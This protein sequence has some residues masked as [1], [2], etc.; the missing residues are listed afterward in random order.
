M[1]GK[2]KCYATM[3]LVAICIGYFAPNYAQYQLSPLAPGL[4]EELGINASQFSSLFTSPMIPA[5]FLSLVAGILV[6][7]FNPKLVVGAALIAS[8]VGAFLN[9]VGNSYGALFLGFAL[10]GL[11]ASFL[12]SCGAKL[13]GAWYEPDQ[14]SAKLGVVYAASTL[15]MTVAIATTAYFPNRT[16]AF[17]MTFILF[18][19]ALF[20]WFVFYRSPAKS[21]TEAKAL[22]ESAAPVRAQESLGVTL[23]WVMANRY[24]WFV[25][26]ALFFVMGGNVI[27]SS[28]VP[29]VLGQRGIGSV[30]AG[31]YSSIYTIGNLVAC[32]VAPLLAKK[33]GG[34]KRTVLIFALLA[35]VFVAFGCNAPEGVLLVLALFFA[36]FF[37]G[38]NIPLLFAVPIQLEGVGPE[39]AGTAGGLVATVELLGAVLLPSYVLLPIAGSNLGVAFILGGV[40][41]VVTAVFS[42]LLPK[43]A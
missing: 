23:K 27:M 35:A 4:M 13:L 42:Q 30:A 16:S 1:E 43:R 3:A 22:E 37:V 18:V 14:I 8:T 6:D 25:G 12:N 2:R 28:L 7:K 34:T 5:I 19:V 33:L 26:L 20:V 24:V 39:L 32:F 31:Y 11:S 36:G 9:L 38:G 10:T 41:L 17:T 29:T 40:C 21:A 15:A